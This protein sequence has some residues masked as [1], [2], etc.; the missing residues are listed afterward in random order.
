MT[1]NPQGLQQMEKPVTEHNKRCKFKATVGSSPS[2][3]DTIVRSVTNY[4]R[5]IQ[6]FDNQC[7]ETMNNK[8]LHP[9]Q[10]PVDLLRYLILTYTSENDTV[11]DNCMGSGSTAIAAIRE[12][13]HWIGFE[14]EKEYY[15]KASA[16]IAKELEQPKLF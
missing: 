5:M 6:F 2:N 14:L 15:D 9:T 16:R 10:K 11:L 8:R 7:G 1:F 3:K 13:R 12:R 4:P